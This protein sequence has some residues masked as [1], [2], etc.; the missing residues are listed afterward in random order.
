MTPETPLEKDPGLNGKV[1][2]LVTGGAGFIGSHL[3]DRLIREGH[4]IIAYDNLSTGVGISV[5]DLVYMFGEVSN[6]NISKVISTNKDKDNSVLVLNNKKIVNDLH[7]LPKINLKMG[8]EKIAHVT[9]GFSSWIEVGG[10]IIQFEEKNG[11]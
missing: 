5:L 8:I 2:A 4:E 3:V 9:G 11:K 7:W 1:T 6:R 10:E